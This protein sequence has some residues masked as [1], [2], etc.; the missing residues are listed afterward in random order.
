MYTQN[1][2]FKDNKNLPSNQPIFLYTIEN[3]DGASNNLNF[4]EWDADVVYDGVTYSKFPIKHDGIG[5]N[6]HGELDSILVT[7]AN[8][9]RAIQ[10]YL[11]AYDLRGKK[12]VIT[13]VFADQLA[14]ADANIKF[15]YYIDNYT[16]NQDTVDFSLSSKYDVIDITLPLAKFYRNYCRWKFKGAECAYAGAETVC[17]K[18]KTTCKNTMGNVARYGGFPSV[19]SQ[20]LFT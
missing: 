19:P 10:A 16:A 8:V 18:R 14:D 3:F 15:T 13:I 9:N 7:V 4:A 11:E 6:S 20:R 17:D 1:A 2:T 12:V 5:E